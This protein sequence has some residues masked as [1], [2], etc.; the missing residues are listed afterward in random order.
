MSVRSASD[1]DD[2]CRSPLIALEAEREFTL[3]ASRIVKEASLM[4]SKEA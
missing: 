4:T 1:P 2:D 3:R